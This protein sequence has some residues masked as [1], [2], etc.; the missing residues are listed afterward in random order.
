MLP[1]KYMQPKH[2]LVKNQK[3]RD[4]ISQTMLKP[5]KASEEDKSGKKVS[6]GKPLD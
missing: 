5:Y 3:R 1:E 4:F 2:L 6:L